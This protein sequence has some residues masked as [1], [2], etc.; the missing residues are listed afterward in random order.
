MKKLR[1]IITIFLLLSLIPATFIGGR[2]SDFK[3]DL[4][5]SDSTDTSNDD[6]SSDSSDDDSPDLEGI[7]RA[8]GYLFKGF[9][10]S[11]TQ[12]YS[13]HPLNLHK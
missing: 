11:S 7:L 3:D 8:I 1:T 6:N 4:K 9:I 5:N 2:L 12:T 10:Y 13:Q